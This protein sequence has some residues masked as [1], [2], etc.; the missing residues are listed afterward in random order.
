MLFV[1]GTRDDLAELALVRA[2]VDRLAA[3]AT[4]VEI[5][6]ADHAFHV[7]RQSGS[8]D[9]AVIERI[10]DVMHDWMARFADPGTTA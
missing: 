3:R 10:A 7:R 4:L 6:D 5:D 2:L 1:Q 8:D 9:A